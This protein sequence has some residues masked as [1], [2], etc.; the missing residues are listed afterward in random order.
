MSTSIR[1]TTTLLD[2]IERIAKAERRTR[3]NWIGITLEDAVN[4]YLAAHPELVE[5]DNNE[6]E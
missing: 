5:G 6:R 2:Q 4:E 1:I 3:N